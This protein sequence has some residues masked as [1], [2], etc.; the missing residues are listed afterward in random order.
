MSSPIIRQPCSD[1]SDQLNVFCQVHSTHLKLV[2]ADAAADPP[3]VVRSDFRANNRQQLV[4]SRIRQPAANSLTP[5]TSRL[6]SKTKFIVIIIN[7]PFNYFKHFLYQGRYY[8]RFEIIS[9]M[10]FEM[11]IYRVAP[12]PYYL[13]FIVGYT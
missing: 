11:D 6:N 8:Y 12:R 7:C 3:S 5:Y 2:E 9:D 10:I 4:K 1:I 13:Y